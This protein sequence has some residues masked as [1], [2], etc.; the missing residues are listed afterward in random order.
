MPKVNE[1]DY[2]R[3]TCGSNY[4]NLDFEVIARIKYICEVLEG[5]RYAHEQLEELSELI[6]NKSIKDS[7]IVKKLK[8]IIETFEGD[9]YAIDLTLKLIDTIKGGGSTNA[10][11]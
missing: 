9:S 7:L 4:N 3:R 11:T 2:K 10:R 1:E 5:N 6:E 8:Q